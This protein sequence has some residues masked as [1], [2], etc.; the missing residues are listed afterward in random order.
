MNDKYDKTWIDLVK[1]T[2]KSE[3]HIISGKDADRLL[4]ELPDEKITNS[5]IEAIV[6][7]VLSN[8]PL[9][10]TLGVRDENVDTEV[11]KT[12]A[13]EKDVLQL[14]RNKGIQDDDAEA[15]L[16]ELRREALEESN[17]ED[18]DK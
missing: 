14:N 7:S 8:R 12:E 3:S 9:C 2:R 17:D 16:E 15:R 1:Q 5:E 18:M 4:G 10:E 11:Q 6:E 13:V